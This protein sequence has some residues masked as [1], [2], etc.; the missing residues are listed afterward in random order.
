MKKMRTNKELI[1][2]SGK[3]GLIALVLLLCGIPTAI[4]AANPT[5]FA[6]ELA[7][8]RTEVEELSSDVESRKDELRGRLRSYVSQ[9]TDLE[10]E[11]ARE[12]MRLKQLREAKAKRVER[13]ADDTQRGELLRPVIER[14]VD[15]LERSVASSLP[16]QKEERLAAMRKIH[17]QNHEGLL[18][19]VDAV[20]R[21]WDRVEDELRLSREN[22]LYR[23]VV[24]LDGEELLVDVARIGMVMLY[25][26]T[27][28]G[29]VGKA[30]RQG[31]EWAFV[32]LTAKEDRD[33]V[34]QLFDSF[35][36]QIR[37]GFFLLP[38]SLSQG[39]V[40]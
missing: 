38:G 39:G 17:K 32:R 12:E 15:A 2:R 19:S 23:Q 29:R 18:R 30:V 25:F 37:S 10:M 3:Y 11:L 28:D 31:D 27:K 7:R 6:A 22:G 13:V 26:K 20:A 24:A 4:Y 8:L 14:S 16:F 21:L 35:K 1:P 36:K 34:L 9:K 33:Q 40:E 5:E